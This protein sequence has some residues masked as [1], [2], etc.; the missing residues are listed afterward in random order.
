[1]NAEQFFP[2]A[3]KNRLESAIREAESKTSGEI[4]P[5]VV[6]RSD[7]YP[8]GAWRAGAFAALLVMF[9]FSVLELSSSAWLT[10]GIARA[11]MYAA[12]GFLAGAAAA[13]FIPLLTLLLVPQQTIDLRVHDRAR[14]AFLSEKI[15]S[16]RER[17][18]IL[19]F[20]SLLERRV[21]VLSDEGINAKVKQ[22]SWDA[23][24]KMIVD[25]IKA[26]QPSEGLLKAINAC[27][28][29]LESEKISK[30][31]DDTNELSDTIRIHES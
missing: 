9:G 18:G 28:S 10:F 29:L 20:L 3:E 25:G 2:P 14:L 19:I 1:M 5:Y 8:E 6:A 13:R 12:A 11:G 17:T 30:R 15:F 16:T 31:I 21:V 7:A 27:G 23:I 26:K 24:V 22:E 4:V